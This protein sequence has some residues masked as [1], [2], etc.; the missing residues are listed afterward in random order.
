[1]PYY[2]ADFGTW[3]KGVCKPFTA[4]DNDDA[5]NIAAQIGKELGQDIVQ[6]RKLKKKGD[7]CGNAFFDFMNG[8]MD[9]R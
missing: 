8:R 1:M 7:I 9:K 6:I 3:E 2:S 5:E 4:K